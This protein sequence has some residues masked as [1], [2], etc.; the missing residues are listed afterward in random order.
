MQISKPFCS[1]KKHATP[2]IPRFLSTRCPS[3]A[4]NYK[5]FN[6]SLDGELALREVDSALLGLLKDAGLLIGR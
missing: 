5:H 3:H 1:K 2:S 4:K 6:L